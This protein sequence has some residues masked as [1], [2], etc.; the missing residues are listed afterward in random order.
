MSGARAWGWVLAVRCRQKLEVPEQPLP[1]EG[2]GFTEQ[3]VWGF[4]EV[5]PC[6]AG[7]LG[8]RRARSRDS[9]ELGYPECMV[10]DIR[11]CSGWL[12][13]SRRVRSRDVVLAQ[14]EA[15]GASSSL[16]GSRATAL[17]SRAHSAQCTVSRARVRS[18]DDDA[19]GKHVPQHISA[20]CVCA[21]YLYACLDI[22]LQICRRRCQLCSPSRVSTLG[23]G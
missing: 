2:A 17:S 16:Q 3:A 13:R 12:H 14:T 4:A 9:W 8:L 10:R 19:H 6:G 5:V 20:A 7:A 21:P 23:W 15:S 22:A 1:W 18:G 11:R